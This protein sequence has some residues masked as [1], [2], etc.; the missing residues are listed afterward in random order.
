[1]KKKYLS[2]IVLFIIISFTLHGQDFGTGE[3]P[4]DVPDSIPIPGILYFLAALLGI[5]LKKIYNARKK[6]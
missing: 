3:D 5:G 6:D 2:L 4:G 1:M